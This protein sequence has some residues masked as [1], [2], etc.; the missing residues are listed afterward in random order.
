MARK[1]KAEPA[2]DPNAWMVTF[3]DLVTLLLTFFV[4]LLSMSTMDINRVQKVMSSFT[5]G[6]GVLEYTDMGALTPYEEQ[7]KS[8][9]QLDLS[10]LPSEEVL[11]DVFLG[12]KIPGATSVF[13]DLSQDLKVRKT[14]KGVSLVF[15]SRILFD[16]GGAVLK[17]EA[18]KALALAAK[19]INQIDRPI[20][21]E[22]HTDSMPL[23]KSS[24]Y[25]SNWELSLARALA[26]RDYLVKKEGVNPLRMR[27][28]ALADA[29]PLGDNET[30][31]GR[32]LNRRIEIVFDWVR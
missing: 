6:S 10:Q 3:S 15:G 17:K 13:D 18:E 8:L 20:S 2:A 30:V 21:V 11:L 28:A 26:V 22:G 5:G 27:V 24:R 23:S 1:K 29:R 19:I 31:E 4:M 9:N 7:L 32:D 14:A 12:R 25:A 16:S